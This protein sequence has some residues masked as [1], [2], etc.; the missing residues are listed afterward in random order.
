MPRLSKGVEG[1]KKG[2]AVRGSGGR[3]ETGG[4]WLQCHVTMSGWDIK[5]QLLSNGKPSELGVF[6]VLFWFALLFKILLVFQ[7]FKY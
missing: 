3:E 7:F 5:L 1:S 2:F 4:G 6:F